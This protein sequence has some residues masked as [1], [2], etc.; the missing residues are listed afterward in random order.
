MLKLNSKFTAA[1][2]ETGRPRHWLL[3]R[4]FVTDVNSASADHWNPQSDYYRELVERLIEGFD[5]AHRPPAYAEK[6]W[7]LVIKII[8]CRSKLF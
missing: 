5:Y 7:R 3:S 4:Q 2:E 8:R 1:L 6:D